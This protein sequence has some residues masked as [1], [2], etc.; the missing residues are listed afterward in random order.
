MKT[1]SI[2]KIGAR[3]Q[4]TLWVASLLLAA[5]TTPP[6]QEMSD[7]RQA[8]E[9]A[10]EA[11]ASQAAPEKMAAAQ[12]ALRMAERLLRDHQF[13]AARHYA[14][15]AKR[16]ALDAQGVAQSKMSAPAIH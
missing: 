3:L 12:A 1:K 11:G 7:A 15:D 4:R 6:V 5:C 13:S 8:V 9:A 10:T 14:V 16:K 2:T